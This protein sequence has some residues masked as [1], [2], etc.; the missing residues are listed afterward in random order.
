[1]NLDL[2]SAP[3]VILDHHQATGCLVCSL[4]HR[5]IVDM[6]EHVMEEGTISYNTDYDAR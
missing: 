5:L 1:M 6:L 2:N 4:M 3:V